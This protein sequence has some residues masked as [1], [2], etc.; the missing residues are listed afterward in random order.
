MYTG[1]RWFKCDLQMQTPGDHYNWDRNDEAYLKGEHTDNDLIDSVDKYLHRCHEVEL[2]VVGVTDHNFIGKDYLET[3][4]KR[5]SVIA[6]KLEKEPLIIFPGFEIEISQG[7]GVHLLCLFDSNTNLG[8]INEIV[9][10]LG[11]PS[12]SR[13]KNGNISPSN[14]TF[15]D[16]IRLV[17][18]DND[19]IVIAAHPLAESGMLNDGFLTNHFQIENFTDPRLLAIEIPKP[20][21]SLPN[22]LQALLKS[23]ERCHAEWR[24]EH[25]IATIMSSDCYSLQEN[26]KGYI[27]KRYSWVRMS[28][29]TINSLKQ[30][31]IDHQSR[32]KLQGHSP[33]QDMEHGFIK[34]LEIE[35]P[36]FLENQIIDFSPNFNCIIGGRGSGKSSILEYIRLCTNKDFYD[37]ESSE[38]VKNTLSEPSRLKLTIEDKNGL[39]DTFEFNINNDEAIITGR[40]EQPTDPQ[41]IFDN[42]GVQIFSQRQISKMAEQT[43]SLLPIIDKITGSDL[44]YLKEEE[45]QIQSKIKNLN[46]KR[47]K[48]LRLEGEKQTLTQEI[49]ELQRQWD[50]F[51]AVREEN[52][53]RNKAQ[54]SKRHLDNLKSN[55]EENIDR[56]EQLINSIEPINDTEIEKDLFKEEEVKDLVKD[57]NRAKFLLKQGIQKELDNY[58]DTIKGIRSEGSKWSNL[59]KEIKEVDDK[60]IKACEKQ[61]LQPEQL[62]QLKDVNLQKQTKEYSLGLKENEISDLMDETKELPGLYEQLHTIWKKQTN[63]RSENITKILSSDTVPRT[64]QNDQPFIKINLECMGDFDHF[65]K[66]WDSINV[67]GNTRLG[68]N[69]Q[70]IGEVLFDKFTEGSCSSPWELLFSWVN[71]KEEVPESLLKYYDQLVELIQKDESNNWDELRLTRIKDGIDIILYREEGS[72]AGSLKD[73]GLS[74]GQ[75]NTA[76]LTLLFADGNDPLII[77]QPEDELDSDF[78]YND[79]VPLIRRVKSQRQ[80]IIASHNANLPVNGD[81]EMI[82]ALQT[83]LGK[84][85]MRTGGG[86][87]KKTVRKAILDI[88]EGS[89]EAFRKRREKYYS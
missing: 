3:L 35:N 69:W 6:K 71:N 49:I 51:V 17:Q 81:A 21:E 33:N 60:F 42:L 73:N 88:M 5:N 29:P 53:E 37:D 47:R 86:L 43:E 50:S 89:E 64:V 55:F 62:E 26:D 59:Y 22:G 44:K 46:E 58:K 85:K 56:L 39:N 84:G 8:Q 16:V 28:D 30:A 83:D 54:N 41:L 72:R 7:M 1:M 76:V 38:R 45:S 61:G 9:A 82:Y 11:L 66:I 27:G 65:I 87:D 78:I 36:D 34:S 80:I 14:A 19:G 12:N 24:R 40:G 13:V 31:F 77:D 70:E 23:G 79:L 75:K 57:F 68:R 25:P 67:R 15:N 48:L 2:E 63:V 52:E 20:I 74:D 4:I 10:Q 18:E 32:I